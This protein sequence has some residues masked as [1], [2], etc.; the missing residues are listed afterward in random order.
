MWVPA[1][2][3]VEG[4]EVEDVAAKGALR[5]EEEGVRVEMGVAEW[6]SRVREVMLDRWQDEW[7]VETKGRHLYGIQGSVRGVG[8]PWGRE[9]GN[10]SF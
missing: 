10:R 8:W 7:R 3:G 9:G 4:N 2:V 5:H 6:R 1:H